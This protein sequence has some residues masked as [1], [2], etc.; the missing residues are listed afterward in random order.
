M[1]KAFRAHLRRSYGTSRGVWAGTLLT[2]ASHLVG[3]IIIPISI[4]AWL[5]SVIRG[6]GQAT[7]SLA[8]IAILYL[9]SIL[10]GWVGDYVFVSSTDER[11]KQLVS[12]FYDSVMEKDVSFFRS[13]KAGA[14]ASLFREYMDSTIGIFRLFR[15]EIVP[16]L[17]I[18]IVPGLILITYDWRVATV[19]AS[20][21][22][23]RIVLSYVGLLKVK[24]LRK[25]ALV[26]YGELSGVMSD[27]M[28][29]LSIVRA[30]ANYEINR[31]RIVGLAAREAELFWDRH[32]MA[33]IF[34]FIL[35]IL[36]AA[37]SILILAL[38]KYYRGGSD[39]AI[40]LTIVALIY[41]VQG[42]QSAQ[43]AGEA[44]QRWNEH[45]ARVKL[46]LDKLS[47]GTVA[48]GVGREDPS[49][50]PTGG[51]IEF[52]SV[53][54]G[55][56]LESGRS[57]IFESLNL[58]IPDGLHFAVVGK[59][60]AGKS[61]LVN[62]IM[63]FD[64]PLRGRVS[65]G[66][67]DLDNV[68]KEHLYH[69]LSYVPQEPRLFNE[70]VED[71]IMFFEPSAPKDMIDSVLKLTSMDSILQSLPQGL[72]TR[73]GEMGSNLSGGERQRAAITRALL[74][75]ASIYIFDEATSAIQAE[76]A[77]EILCNV[78]GFLAGR[79]FMVITHSSEIADLFENVLLVADGDARWLKREAPSS[80]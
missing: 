45:I 52:R 43:G 19:F 1:T 41:I 6:S 67:A 4:A 28:A 9:A 25:R 33:S 57:E 46:G 58:T 50:R 17:I 11:Y 23:L 35:S 18:A 75:Q 16:L 39:E 66:G 21:V 51:A 63:R 48:R 60:G 54:F 76:A 70:T 14:L 78:R 5:M 3:K 59:N 32:R 61:T 31:S 62:L 44:Y 37:C 36:T 40:E 26:V 7:A 74:R 80:A 22:V 71:N 77:R 55:Y 27:Q 30:S 49:Q 42:M 8:V 47:S 53:K 34:E 72:Q 69:S 79:T 13:E 15:T 68:T 56:S 2:A 20:S 24:D 73:A 38:I 29:H 12:M 10:F 64:R 65:V